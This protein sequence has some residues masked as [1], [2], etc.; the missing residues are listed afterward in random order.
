[1]ASTG[2]GAARSGKKRSPDVADPEEASTAEL[3][4]TIGASD[5]IERKIDLLVTAIASLANS[6]N[7]NVKNINKLAGDVEAKDEKATDKLKTSID[8]NVEKS[9]K[10]RRDDGKMNENFIP[11]IGEIVK[12][13]YDNSFASKKTKRNEADMGPY[14]AASEIK[15]GR[16]TRAWI[17]DRRWFTGRLQVS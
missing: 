4:G 11:D 14:M 3:A 10:K 15:G 1:M 9:G 17:G 5:A 6:V 16:K 8:K 13:A 2:G 12:L 7:V